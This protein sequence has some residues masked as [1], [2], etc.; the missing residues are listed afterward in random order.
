MTL[1]PVPVRRSIVAAVGVLALAATLN[2][3]PGPQ[4]SAAAGDSGG[5]RARSSAGWELLL[6]SGLRDPSGRPYDAGA[7]TTAPPAPSP[8]PSQAA[9]PPLATPVAASTVV[10]QVRLMSGSSIPK[11]AYAAYV[12]AATTLGRTEPGCHLSWQLLAGIGRVESD[13]GRLGAGGG[14]TATGT[15]V[16]AILGPR[17]D[18]SA[19]YAAIPDSD[20]GRLDGDPEF[21]RAVGPMQ[22]LPGT[23]TTYGRD[24]NADG[25]RDP[26]NLPDAA[27]AA[28]TY[29]CAAG[30]DLAVPTGVRTAVLAYNHSDAYADLV[31]GLAAAYTGTAVSTVP[32]TPVIVPV[33]VA[34][35]T[36]RPQP[37]GPSAPVPAPAP[38]PSPTCPT[39]TPVPTG[40]PSPTATTSTSP[41]GSSTPTPAPTR[42]PRTTARPTPSGPATPT[43]SATPSPSPSDC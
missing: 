26:E 23:W 1:V 15:V 21:D 33:P 13:H 28:G 9:S 8:A 20:A 18:G 14:V 6:L 22:F 7:A 24:G 12:A 25:Q 32:V 39:A 43:P 29:L 17:L 11:P 31:L 19:G 27:L 35:P 2:G 40:T 3:A 10:E 30:G 4:A 41:P 16:P 36:L 34:P 5:A 38:S 42:T 37:V